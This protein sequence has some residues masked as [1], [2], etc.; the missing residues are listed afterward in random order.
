LAATL[1]RERKRVISQQELSE[2]HKKFVTFHRISV[3]SPRVYDFDQIIENLLISALI[4]GHEGNYSFKQAFGYY[5]FV[6]KFLSENRNSGP[7]KEKILNLIKL[8]QYDEYSNIL[9]FVVHYTKE[10]YILQALIDQAKS[11]FSNYA[12]IKFEDDTTKISGLLE[13]IPALILKRSEIQEYRKQKLLEKDEANPPLIQTPAF[14]DKEIPE[15]KDET[16]EAFKFIANISIASTLMDLMG[17]ILINYRSI[18]GDQQD[19]IAVE[20]Y[21][22]GLRCL[23]GMFE[24]LESNSNKII[25]NIANRIIS[26][27]TAIDEKSIQK[28]AKQNLFYLYSVLSYVLIKTVSNSIG[29]DTLSEVTIAVPR[30]YPYL[31]V[32]LI[33]ISIKLD[34]YNY[35]PLGELTNV[36][37]EVTIPRN[38]APS[39]FINNRENLKPHVKSSRT[40]PFLILRQLVE[41]YL[42]K[43][44]TEYRDRQ[45]ICAMFGIEMSIPRLIT[46]TSEETTKQNE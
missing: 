34:H 9:M 4:E 25:D 32:A 13:E 41:E 21:L 15:E 28:Q 38:P 16:P 3:Y 30:K 37:K 10:D 2:F 1:F 7:I 31:S 39:T 18:P 17:Q 45:R 22:L 8:L 40:F 33:D 14:K 35:F 5:F 11:I 42:Y 12:P 27:G 19:E 6:G 29:S 43:F 23:S 46:Q 44:P 24:L 36:L 26:T 20:I